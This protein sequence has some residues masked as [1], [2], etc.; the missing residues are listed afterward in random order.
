[1]QTGRILYMNHDNPHPSGGVQVIYDH[2]RHLVRNGYDAYVVHFRSGFK[3][4]WFDGQIP[5]LY[6]DQPFQVSPN[7][8]IVIPED[9]AGFL[10][11]F[12]DVPARKIIFC[13]NHFYLFEGI[14]G[15]H[16]LQSLGISGLMACSDIVSSFLR[17]HLKTSLVQTVHNAVTTE[18]FRASSP[19]KL[20]V[21]Y[22]PRKRP[23]EANFIKRLCQSLLD[24][25]LPVTW[26]AIDNMTQEQVAATMAESALFL[27]LNRLEGFGLPPLEAMASGCLVAG[28]TGF[29]AQEYASPENGFWCAEDDL[30][31]CAQSLAIAIKMVFQQ[32]PQVGLMLAAAQKT[33]AAYSPQRQE[34]ELLHAMQHFSRMSQEGLCGLN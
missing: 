24:P 16:S 32:A 33:A 20:Q 4:T 1:M 19:K 5:T 11:F 18:L 13:Q 23:L 9:H 34:Q 8:L 14:R 2:V 6:C 15:D 22:M 28:F 27:S 7:D 3:P 10:E 12:R 26:V 25:T 30:E 17:R 31:G 21:A 29:G